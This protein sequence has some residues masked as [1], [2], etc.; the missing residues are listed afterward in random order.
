MKKGIIAVVVA[1]SLAFAVAAFADK[2][3]PVYKKGDKVF[4]CG[5]GAGCDCL[6]MSRKE[7]K[8]SC[9]K[10][11][12]T[13]VVDKVEAGK[14]FVKVNG[15]ELTFPVKAKYACACG[16]GCTC[17]TVS[18]KPGKCSCGTEMKKVE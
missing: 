4:V 5:C 3:L 9:N 16:E 18:Q 17:G 1:L 7:G 11:L 2:D 13:T 8:C 6:T 10:P 12:A 15:K 14:I